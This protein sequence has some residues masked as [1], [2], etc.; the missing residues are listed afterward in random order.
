MQ[1]MLDGIELRQHR[2]RLLERV[3]PRPR[4]DERADG[5]EL[6]LERRHDAEVRAGAAHAP[7]E[8]RLLLRARA[9]DVAVCCDEL[10]LEQ[11]VDRQAVLAHEP[12]DAGAE[13]RPATPVCETVP[14]GTASTTR[15]PSGW[16]SSA[17]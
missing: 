13:R 16:P 4:R 3:E 10:D 15:S 9:D 7:E 12:A 17:T 14:A 2:G 11:V 8:L 5:M 1:V 6:E